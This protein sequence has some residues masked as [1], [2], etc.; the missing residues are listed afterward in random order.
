[1]LGHFR[2]EVG[3]Y[4]QWVLVEQTAWIDECRDRFCDERASY[5]EALDRHYHSGARHASVGGRPAKVTMFDLG[6]E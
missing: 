1:M 5:S 4:S 3:H 6:S 2:H